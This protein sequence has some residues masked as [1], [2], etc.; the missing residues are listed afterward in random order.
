MYYKDSYTDLDGKEISIETDI[1]FAFTK[2]LR[3]KEKIENKKEEVMKE[4]A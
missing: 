1:K 3:K 4:D 2:F